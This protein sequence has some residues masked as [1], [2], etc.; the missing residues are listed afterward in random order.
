MSLHIPL[1]NGDWSNNVRKACHMYCKKKPVARG[2]CPY[3][4][5][6]AIVKLCKDVKFYE[7]YIIE[8]NISYAEQLLWLG[9]PLLP[10][11]FPG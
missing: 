4:S 9:L 5:A 2:S 3:Y 1:D 7:K 11:E 8:I 10:P 6:N